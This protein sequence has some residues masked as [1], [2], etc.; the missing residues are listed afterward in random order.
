MNYFARYLRYLRQNPEGYWFKR[1]LYG[2]GWIPATWQG[3]LML[4]IFIAI[5]AWLLVPFVSN[6]LPSISDIVSFLIKIFAWAVAL[7]LV[8]Y[9]T[10]EPLKWQWGMPDD[11]PTDNDLQ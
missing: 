7:V 10:G 8:C 2:W 6:Q 9:L 4:A 1:K 5:F 11:R 3:W